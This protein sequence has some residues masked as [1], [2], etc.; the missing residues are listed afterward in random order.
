MK[1]KIIKPNIFDKFK[2]IS[3]VTLVNPEEYIFTTFSS[4]KITDAYT[5]LEN[6]KM[7][8][9]QLNVEFSKMIF[10]KQVH[11]DTIRIVDEKSDSSIES[12]AMITN[13]AGIILN[14][15][16]ADC[17]AIL[18]Y[19]KKNNVVAGV[20]SGWRGTALEICKKTIKKLMN[21]FHSQTEDLLIYISPCAGG[22]N[23]EVGSEVAKLFPN[24]TIPK[25]DGKYLFDNKKEIFNSLLNLGVPKEN[26][27]IS[28]I[29]TIENQD[30]HS[31][32]RDG[33]KSGRM[34]AFIGI[35]G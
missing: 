1:F 32:R 28:D 4:G 24:S 11:G 30:F 27:E 17:A 16:I 5:V 31:F 25:S 33:N 22:D 26:I 6:R 18:I 9:N 10:Q 12:D 35:M 3:G 15:S 14:I 20:H 23:Y 34:S 2:V 19:D 7:L 21:E 13:Q 8:S 29:C